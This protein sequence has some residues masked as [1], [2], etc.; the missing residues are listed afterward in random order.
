MSNLPRWATQETFDAFVGGY[1]A[2][3]N[4]YQSYLY[5]GKI[6]VITLI[7][8]GDLSVR[9]EWQCVGVDGQ[10]RRSEKHEAGWV[11]VNKNYQVALF[12]GPP[13]SDLMLLFTEEQGDPGTLRLFGGEIM[14]DLLTFFPP[15]TPEIVSPDQIRPADPN[16]PVDETP[17]YHRGAPGVG[18]TLWKVDAEGNQ[19]REF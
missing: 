1:L 7:A 19:T 9:F 5:Y 3:T 17:R 10:N 2:V 15:G 18:V 8:R 14:E 11:A 6:S 4:P 13:E 16:N 12:T